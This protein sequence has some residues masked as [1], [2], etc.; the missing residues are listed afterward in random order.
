MPSCLGR[1]NCVQREPRA[2]QGGRE[3]EAPLSFS[4]GEAATS[5][6]LQL[7]IYNDL[8]DDEVSWTFQAERLAILVIPS[9]GRWASVETCQPLLVTFVRESDKIFV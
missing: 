9:H 8:K 3:M 6:C 5:P 2:S 1:P 7:I 4:S